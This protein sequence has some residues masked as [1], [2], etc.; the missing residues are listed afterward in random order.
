MEQPREEDQVGGAADGEKLGQGLN[1]G[2]YDRLKKRHE[3]F[4]VLCGRRGNRRDF[5]RPRLGRDA[6]ED[7]GNAGCGAACCF[8]EGGG[9]REFTAEDAE[10]TEFGRER[11]RR[12][13][14]RV[15]KWDGGGYPPRCFVKSVQVAEKNRVAV[16]GF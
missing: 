16:Y 3:C 10:V 1:Q 7:E 2:E 15:P 12:V 9:G 13:V 5:G 11:M 6:T 4:G 14:G 8:G